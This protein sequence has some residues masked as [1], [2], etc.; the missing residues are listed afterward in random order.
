MTAA[1][2]ISQCLRVVMEVSGWARER[3]D[4]RSGEPGI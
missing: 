2:V 1:P 4:A 3:A